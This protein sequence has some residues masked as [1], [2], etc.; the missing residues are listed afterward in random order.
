MLYVTLHYSLMARN[1]PRKGGESRSDRG[2][3]YMPVVPMLAGVSET[4]TIDLIQPNL[5][6]LIYVGMVSCDFSK[7]LLGSSQFHIRRFGFGSEVRINSPAPVAKEFPRT[8][9]CDFLDPAL[10][11]PQQLYQHGIQGQS[12]VFESIEM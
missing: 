10:W 3:N 7:S 4:I 8:W 11:A 9:W 6:S 2:S 1:G 5:F 12:L